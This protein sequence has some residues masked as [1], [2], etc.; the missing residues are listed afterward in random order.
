MHKNIKDQND[1]RS[2]WK[3]SITKGYWEKML[4]NSNCFMHNIEKMA[5]FFLSLFGDLRQYVWK[6]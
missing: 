4:L 2:T 3:K 6:G 1:A 5:K